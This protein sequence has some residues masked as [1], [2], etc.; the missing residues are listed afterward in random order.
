M[1]WI[2]YGIGVAILVADAAA[3]GFSMATFNTGMSVMAVRMGIP[4]GALTPAGATPKLGVRTTV[5]LWALLITMLVAAWMV[6]Q[7]KAGS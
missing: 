1:K 5:I 3:P 2:A 7:P 4:M 6:S